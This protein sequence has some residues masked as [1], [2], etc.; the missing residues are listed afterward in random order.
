[1][2]NSCSQSAPVPNALD[3]T[4]RMHVPPDFASTRNSVTIG[5]TVAESWPVSSAQPGSAYSSRR[6]GSQPVIVPSD[7]SSPM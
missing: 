5:V 1:M 6:V 4:F 2:K 3:T 7:L